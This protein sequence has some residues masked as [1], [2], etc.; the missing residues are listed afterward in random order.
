MSVT[1]LQTDEAILDEV[2][3]AVKAADAWDWTSNRF[4]RRLSWLLRT[5][6]PEPMAPPELPEPGAE[7]VERLA[8]AMRTLIDAEGEAD[9]PEDDEDAVESAD[10]SLR[11]FASVALRAQHAGR[12]APGAQQL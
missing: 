8:A 2:R 5:R 6:V 4:R 7:D 3:A 12:S 11:Y 10:S 9:F 1:E